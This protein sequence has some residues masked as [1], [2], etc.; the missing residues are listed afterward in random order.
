MNFDLRTRR[1]TPMADLPTAGERL[2][3]ALARRSVTAARVKAA[4]ICIL[5]GCV[6]SWAVTAAITWEGDP[7]AWGTRLRAATLLV[8]APLIAL[9][10]WVAG[11]VRGRS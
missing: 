1:P 4:A 2:R 9:A 8:S 10:A 5:I 7:A 11:S 6:G 3:D